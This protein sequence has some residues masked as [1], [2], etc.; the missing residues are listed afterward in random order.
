MLVATATATYKDAMYR[1]VD[2]WAWMERCLRNGERVME[3]VGG[4]GRLRWGIGWV[5]RS[6]YSLGSSRVHPCYC[7]S[8]RTRWRDL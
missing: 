2:W 8:C 7:C 5:F 1:V 6:R 3:S 4:G